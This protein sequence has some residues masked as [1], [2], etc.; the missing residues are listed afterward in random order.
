[1]NL[2]FCLQSIVLY[3]QQAT[4]SNRNE[5]QTANQSCVGLRAHRL[6]QIAKRRR[7]VQIERRRRVVGQYPL[8]SRKKSQSAH[9]II[10]SS[11]VKCYHTGNTGYYNEHPFNISRQQNLEQQMF[12]HRENETCE[13]SV[14]ERPAIVLRCIRYAK[15][16]SS[17]RCQL[18]RNDDELIDTVFNGS[19]V[20][21]MCTNVTQT[22]FRTKGRA[23]I[24]IETRCRVPSRNGIVE[25]AAGN[26]LDIKWRSS[27]SLHTRAKLSS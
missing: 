1:M 12:D 18:F 15:F 20:S 6:R 26:H 24:R 10:R 22:L 17:P 25:H 3:R 11:K 9:R 16:D 23:T 14:N 5:S 19:H 4:P 13:R 21:I 7:I 8:S 27:E 2:A